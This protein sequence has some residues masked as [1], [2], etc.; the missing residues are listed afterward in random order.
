MEMLSS[1]VLCVLFGLLFMSLALEDLQVEQIKE[2][3][4]EPNVRYLSDL[5][6]QEIIDLLG[7]EY[8]FGIEENDNVVDLD[9]YKEKFRQRHREQINKELGIENDCGV[10]YVPNE[11]TVEDNGLFS[12]NPRMHDRVKDR[13]DDIRKNHK[14]LR[15]INFIRQLELN[16]GLW[17]KLI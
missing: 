3:V 9:F 2:E 12:L 11:D 4:L 5:T 13:M 10:D 1:V 7:V 15:D 6:G 8:L 16:Y 14:R 17:L